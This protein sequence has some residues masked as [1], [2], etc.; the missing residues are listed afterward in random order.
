VAATLAS[1][2]TVLH[3]HGIAGPDD[4]DTDGRMTSIR[5][6]APRLNS[7]LLGLTTVA[8]WATKRRNT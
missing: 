7:Q 5:D 2:A 6:E 4:L 8:G 1:L 3:A